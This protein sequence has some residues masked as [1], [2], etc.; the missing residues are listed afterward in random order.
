VLR[1]FQKKAGF[2]S[3]ETLIVA[4]LMIALGAYAI[5]E[6]YNVSNMNTDRAMNRV[7]QAMFV[8]PDDY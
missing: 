1:K 2:V 8:N 3:I 5:S 6:F 4:G 7:N